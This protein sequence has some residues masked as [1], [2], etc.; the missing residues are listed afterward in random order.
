MPQ[1][2]I[3]KDIHPQQDKFTNTNKL[4][5][6]LFNNGVGTLTG[7]TGA[8]TASVSASNK[9]YYYT[10]T[11][12]SG[13]SGV[14]YFDVA[15]GNY[16]GYGSSGSNYVYATKAIYK[17]YANVLLDDPLLKFQFS[18]VS[19]SDSGTDEESIYIL[20]VKSGKMKDRVHTKWTLTLSGSNGDGTGRTLHLTNYTASQYASIAGNYFKVIS[21]SA[22]VPHSLSNLGWDGNMHTTYGHFYPNLGVIVFSEDALSGSLPGSTG[23]IDSGSNMIHGK[24][25]TGGPGFAEDVTTAGLADNAGKFAALFLYTGS[26]LVMRSEQDLNQTTYTCRLTSHEYNFTSNPTFIKSGSALG[27]ILANQVGDPT[28]YVSGIGLYNDHREL[29]AVA[30]LNQAMKKSFGLELIFQVKV[31]G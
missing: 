11:Q 21:G 27:D 3:F 1:Y 30:K 28:V 18:D 22:G 12:D 13:S 17:Q 31:D 7:L 8:A 26:S 29:I 20:H 25:D 23:N 19:G 10:I 2:T 15:Y 9:V 6:G 16:N 4:T 5:V 24:W 14:K